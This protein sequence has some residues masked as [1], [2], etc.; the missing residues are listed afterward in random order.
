MSST[1]PFAAP[2][3]ATGIKWADLKGSLLLFTVHG[4]EN[5]IKTV[6]GDAQAVRADVAVLDGEQVGTVY[7]DTLV[8]PKVLISQIKSSVGGMVLARLGQGSAKPGQSAPWTLTEATDGDK[9]KGREYLAQN[10]P[11]PF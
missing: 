7:N 10:A 11:T 6:H 8:F 4:V 3:T 1:D 5:G 2:S 9:A